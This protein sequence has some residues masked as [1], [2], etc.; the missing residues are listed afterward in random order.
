MR[1]R[2]YSLANLTDGSIGVEL[3]AD[4]TARRHD[5]RVLGVGVFGLA[6][7]LGDILDSLVSHAANA[8]RGSR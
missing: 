7:G 8:E 6:S 4:G 5:G 2:S 3:L 1:K